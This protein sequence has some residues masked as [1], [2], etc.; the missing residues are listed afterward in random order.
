[1]SF[2][3]AYPHI[4]KE[5]LKKQLPAPQNKKSSGFMNDSSTVKRFRKAEWVLNNDAKLQDEVE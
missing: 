3:L 4:L 1:M 5:N 2:F